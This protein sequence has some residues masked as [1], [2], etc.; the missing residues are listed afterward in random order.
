ML[1]MY[2]DA[3]RQGGI[4]QT[5]RR[6]KT[7]NQMLLVITLNSVTLSYR[8]FYHDIVIPSLCANPSVA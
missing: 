3:C 5:V 1:P 2:I 8:A 6:M 4:V 7:T